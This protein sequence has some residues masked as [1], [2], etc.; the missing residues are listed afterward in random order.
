MAQESEELIE[1]LPVKFSPVAFPL[2]TPRLTHDFRLVCTLQSKISV[3][4]TPTGGQRN[5]IGIGPGWFA[6]TWGNGTV[7]PVGQDNQ[8]VSPSDL[9]TFVST[10]YLLQTTEDGDGAKPAFITVH[11]EGGRH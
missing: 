5:W 11:T 2:P 10:H 7:V 4:P 6:A 3:G 9:S 1:G 8:V